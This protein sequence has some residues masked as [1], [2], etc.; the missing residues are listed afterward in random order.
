MTIRLLMWLTLTVGLLL[1]VGVW[2]VRL[3]KR[4][5]HFR[6]I[7][8]QQASLDQNYRKVV[9]ILESC[10]S[11]DKR[12]AA[13]AAHWVER[14]ADPDPRF[15]NQALRRRNLAISLHNVR[16]AAW[17]IEVS[18]RRLGHFRAIADHYA[19]LRKKYERAATRPWEKVPPDPP[20]PPAPADPPEPKPAPRTLRPIRSASSRRIAS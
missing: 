2:G 19:S 4:G 12:M 8:K 14:F 7:A 10:V 5:A 13:L 6:Q 16:R 11:S 17:Q 1:G 15:G 18:G 9:P 20:E 3:I